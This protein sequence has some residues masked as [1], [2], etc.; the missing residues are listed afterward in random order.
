MFS[1]K[2]FAAIA[3]VP[4]LTA[5]AVQPSDYAKKLTMTVNPERYGSGLAAVSGLPVPVRLSASITGFSY[6]DVTQSGSDKDLLFV[7]G[8]KHQ[9]IKQRRLFRLDAARFGSPPPC[10]RRLFEEAFCKERKIS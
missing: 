8:P 1:K 5:F 9:L 3:L 7:D 4:V 2:F 6:S 10:H